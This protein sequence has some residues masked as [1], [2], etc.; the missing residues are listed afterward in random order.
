MPSIKYKNTTYSG[1]SLDRADGVSYDN[2][3]SNL[4]ATNVQDALDKLAKVIEV[5]LIINDQGA[6]GSG[7]IIVCGRIATLSAT[8]TPTTSGIT[9]NLAWISDATNPSGL[10]EWCKPMYD[11]W[12]SC[13]FYRTNDGQA[14]EARMLAN[15]HLSVSTPFYNRDLKISGTWITKG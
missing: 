8:I 4:I 15:G 6:T 10:Y 5:P 7:R 9:L 3:N 13:D 11:W 14:A 12:L 2:T 1:S